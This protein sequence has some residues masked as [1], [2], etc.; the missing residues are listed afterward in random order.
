[1]SVSLTIT[2]IPKFLYSQF[3][4]TPPL[5]RTDC[6]GKTIIVTGANVG[7]GKEAARHYV[8]LGADRVILGVRTVGKGEEAKRDIESSTRRADVV[9]VW[10]LDLRNYDSVK[11]FAQRAS[12]LQRLD[13]IVENAGIATDKY[14]SVG[15]NESTITV[16]VVSTFLLA[17]LVMPTLQ[18]TARNFNIMPTLS[19]VSSVVHGLIPFDERHAPS[20]FDTLNDPKEKSMG[21]RYPVSKLLEVLVCREIAKQHPISQLGVTLNFLNPGLCHSELRREAGPI[22]AIV[23]ALVARTTEVG[24]RTL[25]H[26]GLASP[27][28][29]GKYLSDCE[30]TCCSPF[31]ENED[32]AEAHEKV[33][34]ELA[35]KLEKIQPG[36]TKNLSQG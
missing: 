6:T 25:V 21:Y 17:L 36:I 13:S 20:I 32:G 12:T 27:D 22:A 8:R 11:E 24:S 26:A 10:Q 30:V 23:K 2:L 31:V 1:M 34:K 9:E 16:N 28:T 29:H 33:R 19:I 35:T 18:R 7:L 4:V 5:P 3:F 14:E 15:G